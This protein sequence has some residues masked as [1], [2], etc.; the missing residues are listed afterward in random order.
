ML[1]F[2]VNGVAH[3]LPDRAQAL[4]HYPHM[5]E[6]LGLLFVSGI[7]SRRPDNTVEGPGDI[8]VQTRAVIENIRTI[9]LAAGADLGHLVDV[10]AYLVDMA[11][12]AGYNEVYNEY[13][14]AETGPARTTVAVK[15]LPG[16][17]L[18]IEIKAVALAPAERSA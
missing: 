5:R 10:T 4:A 3:I 2:G 12:Y 9:L 8:R 7:S 17:D 6:A 14:A 15:A 13:F 18:L 1:E 16:P 11:D